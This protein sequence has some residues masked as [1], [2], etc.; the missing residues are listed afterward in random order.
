MELSADISA[1]L[2]VLGEICQHA[3]HQIISQ[4]GFRSGMA[5]PQN[6]RIRPDPVMYVM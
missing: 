6:L 4:D 5:L 1:T 2:I 3:V